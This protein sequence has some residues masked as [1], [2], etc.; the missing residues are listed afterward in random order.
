L[1]DLASDREESG[2]FSVSPYAGL[3]RALP[4]FAAGKGQEKGNIRDATQRDPRLITRL[5]L[6]VAK[7]PPHFR[8]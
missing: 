6:P 5:S 8:N 1:P 2:G 3:C 4:A 7:S